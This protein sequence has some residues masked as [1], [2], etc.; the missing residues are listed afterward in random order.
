MW[1]RCKQPSKGPL[2]TKA[3]LPLPSSLLGP[4][5]RPC[6]KSHANPDSRI[7]FWKKDPK[8]AFLQGVLETHSPSTPKT[9]VWAAV[10]EFEVSALGHKHSVFVCNGWGPGYIFRS[11]EART[12]QMKKR[13]SGRKEDLLLIL[14]N[15]TD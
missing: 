4:P 11:T 2:L 12:R 5:Q 10:Q 9:Q 15:R 1:V 13:T 7:H 6:R 3:L 8:T 14:T